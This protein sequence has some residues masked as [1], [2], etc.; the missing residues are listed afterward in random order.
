MQQRRQSEILVMNE[1]DLY[2]VAKNDLR[3]PG[4]AQMGKTELR[5]AVLAHLKAANSLIEDGEAK[6]AMVGSAAA[7]VA[8][9]QVAPSV[10]FA[11]HGSY[12]D[13]EFPNLVGK[14]IREATELL[15][16]PLGID[17][18]SR[19]YLNKNETSNTQYTLRAG[20]HIEFNKRASAKG[21]L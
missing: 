18:D 10:V 17:K 9:A 19:V 11:S 16:E 6:P 4:C 14:T 8:A 3:I 1:N 2:L 7:P 21:R 15:R 13:M 20:D 12:Q 5:N